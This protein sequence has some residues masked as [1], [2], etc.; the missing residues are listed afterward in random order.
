MLDADVSPERIALQCTHILL[1]EV[2]F[3]LV[4]EREGCIPSIIVTGRQYPTDDA[5]GVGG[6]V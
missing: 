6:V 2:E 1:Q 3:V 4:D 5:S